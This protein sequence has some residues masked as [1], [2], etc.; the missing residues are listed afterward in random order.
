MQKQQI[1]KKKKKKKT[2][3]FDNSTI[4]QFVRFD[5]HR[6]VVRQFVLKLRIERHIAQLLFDLSNRFEIGRS[7][8]CITTLNWRKNTRDKPLLARQIF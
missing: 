1:Q 3:Y 6:C 7:I 5:Q 4:R 8:E 2:T